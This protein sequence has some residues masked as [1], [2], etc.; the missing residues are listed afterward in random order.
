MKV[1]NSFY[2]QC[3]SV[4]IGNIYCVFFHR[5]CHKV[6]VRRVGQIIDSKLYCNV[7]KLKYSEST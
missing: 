2:F 4:F 6:D 3:K 1:F 7:M 5:V